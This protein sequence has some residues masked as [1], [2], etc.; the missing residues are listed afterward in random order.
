MAAR[1]APSSRYETSID[2]VGLAIGAG[3]LMGGAIAVL[4]MVFSGP[5][6]VGALVAGLAIGSLMTALAITALAAIPW[7][8]LHAS[9]RRGPVA[10]A[11]LGAAIGF[12]LFLGGQTYGYGMFTAPAMDSRTW[13]YRWASGVLTSLVMAAMSAGVAAVMWRVAYRKVG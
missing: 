10:A 7:A 13:L 2:R 9:G 5:V 1:P 8:L 3:G 11:I 4:L 6:G 12:V